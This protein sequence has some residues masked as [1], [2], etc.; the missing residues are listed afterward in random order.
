MKII[1]LFSALTALVGCAAT[2]ENMK[3]NVYRAGQVNQVQEVKTVTIL[4]VLPAQIEVDNTEQKKNAQIAGG[5][6][7][8]LLGGLGAGFGTK[9]NAGATVGGT[10]GGAALGLA[11][12]SMVSDKILVDGVSLAFTDETGKT[13]NSAQVGRQCEFRPGKAIMI[14]TS[15]TETRI[16]PNNLA[17]CP[18]VKK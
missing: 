15:A 7:G 1:A 9:G 17:A 6:I 12:A 4:A 11:G 2:G 3:S 10:A 14:S 13:L 16:Q 5:A 8:A 18:A